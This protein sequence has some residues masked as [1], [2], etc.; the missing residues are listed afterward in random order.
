[1]CLCVCTHM[2]GCLREPGRTWDPLE[3]ELQM[4]VNCHV[5]AGNPIEVLFK[6]SKLSST[7]PSLCGITPPTLPPMDA[8]KGCV[9]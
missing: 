3:L 5:G 6:G 4:V 2:C 9:S 1:M 7:E 8:C